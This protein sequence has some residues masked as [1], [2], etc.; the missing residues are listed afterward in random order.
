[1]VKIRTYESNT[2]LNPTPMDPNVAANQGKEIVNIGEGLSGLGET[3]QKLQNKR[4][5]L[6]AEIYLSKTQQDS[7]HMAYTDPD[8]DTLEDRIQDRSQKNVQDAANLIQDPMTRDSFM[9]KATLNVERRNVPL[10]NTIYRRQSQDVKALLHQANDEDIK[11]YQSLA[12]PAEREL[13]RNKIIDRTKTAINDGHINPD[14]GQKHLDS[15]LKQMDVDQ[16]K[17]DMALDAENTYKQLQKGDEGLY[18]HVSP[19]IRK[20]YADQAEKMIAK[21]GSENKLIFGIAQNH[22]ENTLIDKMANNT[23]TQ[24][25]INNS[26]LMGVNGIPPRP[27]FVKA[28]TEALQDPFPTDPVPEKYNKL[29]QDVLN[30]D[31]DAIETKVEVLQ[32]RGITPAQKAHLLTTAMREDPQEGKKSIDQ[33]I[34]TGIQNNKQEIMEADVRL[35]KEQEDRKSFLRGVTGMFRNHAKDDKHL[36]DLQQDYFSKVQKAK[37]QEEMLGIANS[38]LN[39]DTLTRNPKISTADSKGTIF[40]DKTTGVKRRYYPDG[41]WEPVKNA[42]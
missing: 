11:E 3:L 5:T 12:D 21:Q 4:D 6:K 42:R 32:T 26:Q 7:R 8:L 23:L 10:Y 14:V 38:V 34:Q 9:E 25:D 39:K 28:A 1:M 17:N 35:K 16:I 22:A 29:V 15:M 27:E 33:L 24:E 41:H 37:D 20:Q 13:V 36:A 40:M 31:K 18:K 19:A 2:G 30:P